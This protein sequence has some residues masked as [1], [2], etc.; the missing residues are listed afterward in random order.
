MPNGYT[1][2]S[3]IPI[4]SYRKG[5]CVLNSVNCLARPIT[6]V[7]MYTLPMT[8]TERGRLFFGRRFSDL[9]MLAEWIDDRSHVAMR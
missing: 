3:P 5:F 4:T 9:P 7:S 6:P 2:M 1:R 8:V